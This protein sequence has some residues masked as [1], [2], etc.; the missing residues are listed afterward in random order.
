MT[1][2]AAIDPLRPM[3]PSRRESDHD[4]TPELLAYMTTAL[5]FFV[6]ASLLL[7]PVPTENGNVIYLIVGQ[8]IT[9]WLMSLGYYYSTTAN[10]K[11]KDRMLA[12]SVP[13]SA[14]KAP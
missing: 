6:T 10:T 8:I 4:R 11:N 12:N 1:E 7:R 14:A 3:Q 9:G 2:T 5:V 13:V